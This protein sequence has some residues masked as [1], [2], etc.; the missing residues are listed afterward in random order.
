M[1]F[2][3][4]FLTRQYN[5]DDVKTDWLLKYNYACSILLDSPNFYNMVS[6]IVELPHSDRIQNHHFS[7]E[8]CLVLGA[9]IELDP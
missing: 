5:K 1:K 2:S 6:E 4:H 9:Q 8:S 7:I 3:P